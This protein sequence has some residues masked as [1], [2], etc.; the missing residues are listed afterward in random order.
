MKSGLATSTYLIFQQIFPLTFSTNF[1]KLFF[2]TFPILFQH[3]STTF[4]LYKTFIFLKTFLLYDGYCITYAVY[5]AIKSEKSNIYFFKSQHKQTF[6]WKKKK[7][8]Y[9]RYVTIETVQEL[10][11]MS[12]TTCHKAPTLSRTFLTPDM[13]HKLINRLLII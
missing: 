2:H 4:P 12:H 7:K 8:P 13:Y 10:K 1:W 6:F 3:S 11:P 5:W 9:N